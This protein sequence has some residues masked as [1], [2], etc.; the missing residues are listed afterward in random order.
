MSPVIEVARP[1][2][3]HYPLANRC[4]LALLR[5][6]A[7]YLLDPGL[8]ELRFH[9]RRSGARIAL[10]VM[11]AR[12]GDRTIVLVGDAPAKTWWRN[13]RTPAPVQIRRG[14][15]IRAGIARVLRPGDT[16]YIA[17]AR[18]YTNRHRLV[19]QPTDRLIVIEPGESD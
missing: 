16:G 4:V 9:G 19:P 8:C 17:A 11:Y 15:V 5:S 14:G 7:R 3:H 13:F 18:A 10:P 2:R 6:P 12:A 1:S